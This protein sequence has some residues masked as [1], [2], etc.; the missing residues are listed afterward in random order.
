M[1]TAREIDR[2]EL[3]LVRPG[4]AFFHVSGAGHEALQFGRPFDFRRLAPPALSRQGRE[5]CEENAVKDS[6]RPSSMCLGIVT[7]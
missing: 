3:Q 6:L 1:S 7:K 4:Q 5:A 2:V